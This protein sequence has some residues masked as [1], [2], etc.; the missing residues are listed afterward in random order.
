MSDASF[1]DFRQADGRFA[2]GNRGGPGRPR[3]RE[4]PVEIEAPEIRA[5]RDLLPATAA[6]TNALLNGDVTVE[7]EPRLLALKA[8]IE[9]QRGER[10]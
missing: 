6:V 9:R 1:A 7:F 10:P 8:Q 4:R 2:K 3:A 5:T